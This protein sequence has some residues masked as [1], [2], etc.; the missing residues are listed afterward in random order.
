MLYLKM[1]LK[2]RDNNPVFEEIKSNGN[3]GIPCIVINDGEK[4]LFGPPED[5]DLLR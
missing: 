3:V 1:F 2:Y 4:I 5:M